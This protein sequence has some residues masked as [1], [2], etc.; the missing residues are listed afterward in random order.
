MQQPLQELE[1]AS[2]AV[3]ALKE[4]Q[5]QV[6]ALRLLYN[7]ELARASR[8]TL[9]MQRAQTLADTAAQAEEAWR[10]QLLKSDS[11][12]GHAEGL[13]AALNAQVQQLAE[14]LAE[15]QE[16]LAQARGE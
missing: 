3:G 7:Q 6:E 4:S 9:D 1:V 15:S 14:D 10:R 5:H 12:V 2:E 16:Q 8:A 13:T 11:R